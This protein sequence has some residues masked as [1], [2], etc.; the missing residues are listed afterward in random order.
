ML[1]I[2]ETLNSKRSYDAYFYNIIC[3]F[4]MFILEL[5]IPD[6]MSDITTLLSTE[7]TKVKDIFA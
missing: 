6:Y 2:L 7:G 3:V 4:E 5:K 1:K